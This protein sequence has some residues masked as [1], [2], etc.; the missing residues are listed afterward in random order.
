MAGGDEHAHSS[1]Q[2]DAKDSE[3]DGDA[4]EEILEESPCKRWSKRREQVKQRDVPGID[5]AYL[6]MDNETGQD[7]CCIGSIDLFLPLVYY[8]SIHYFTFTIIKALL[9]RER[10]LATRSYLVYNHIFAPDAINH[11]VKTCREN[12]RNMHYIAPEYEYLTEVTPAADIYSFGICALEIAVT[13]GLT[14]CQNGSSEGP[15][16]PEGLEKALR[17]LEDSNQWVGDYKYNHNL[18]FCYFILIKS[19]I[20]IT[21]N[22]NHGK[23]KD[24]IELCLNKDPSKRPTARELLFHPVLFEVAAEARRDGGMREMAYCQVPAF[25]HDLE[26]I[27]EDVRNGI[28]PLTA[29][30]PLAHQPFKTPALLTNAG[31]PPSQPSGMGKSEPPMTL[32]VNSQPRTTHEPEPSPSPPTTME[33]NEHKENRAIVQMKITTEGRELTLWLQL[34]DQMNRQLTTEIGENDTASS[35]TYNLVYHG[36]I[37]GRNAGRARV[38]VRVGSA[39]LSGQI[40]DGVV[41]TGRTAGCRAHG[42]GSAR[43]GG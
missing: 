22:I 31:I 33:D 20:L 19:L 38:G 1:V 17:S 21:V 16:T 10:W 14:G 32:L 5:V 8:H 25:Q 39:S 28:Y 26:K 36:F 18:L 9:L 6:A 41:A 34:E 2:D 7:F 37:C 42:C 24:F 27:V 12:L 15:M 40:D 35:L 11:H 3:S 23:F 4:A 43:H 13:G 29:F 30:A